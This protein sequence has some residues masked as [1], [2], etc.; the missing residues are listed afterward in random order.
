MSCAIALLA[1]SFAAN[2]GFVVVNPPVEKKPVAK[3]PAPLVTSALDPA[4]RPGLIEIGDR[5]ENIDLRKGFVRDLPLSVAVEQLAPR[6][7]TR[8]IQVTGDRKASWDAGAKGA[9][10][11]DELKTLAVRERLYGEVD[12]TQKRVSITDRE[13]KPK[14]AVAPA[15]PA[16]TTGAAGSSAASAPPA[17]AA[18]L[19]LPSPVV[20]P[21][22]DV[23]KGETLMTALKR[24]CAS[25]NWT[26]LWK[27]TDD[28]RPDAA[29]QLPA[30]LAFEDAVRELMRSVWVGYPDM[31]ATAYK[32]RVLV[33][34]SKGNTQ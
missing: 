15:K 28:I 9:L 26:L 20:A 29:I 4:V 3:P 33:I 2:A 10:W 32:N 8:E 14:L 6:Q 11:I 17:A 23:R 25:A 22:Y 30:G 19:S 27:S 31:T 21:A 12:W 13:P 16:Q 18:P 1:V 24:W 5:P 34:E 7:W